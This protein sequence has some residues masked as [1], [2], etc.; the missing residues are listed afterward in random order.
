M[1]GLCQPGSPLLL[2]LLLVVVVPSELHDG[3]WLAMRSQ[4]PAII[5]EPEIR[6]VRG[7]ASESKMVWTDPNKRQSRKKKAS[8]HRGI[9]L[10]Q[11][12]F[13]SAAILSNQ[14]LYQ[15]KFSK[16]NTSSQRIGRRS[17]FIF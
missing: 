8:T 4:R 11:S 14:V 16:V 17:P 7:A 2:L 15:K 13:Y 9:S 5:A 3:S 6:G 10:T 12:A 1:A